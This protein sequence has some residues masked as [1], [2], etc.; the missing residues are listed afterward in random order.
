MSKVMSARRRTLLMFFLFVMFGALAVGYLLTFHLDTVRRIVQQQMLD[1]FGQNLQVGDIQVAFFPSPT[2]TLT[3]LQILESEQGEP[4]FHAARIQMD[5]SF[6]S[7]L[8]DEFVPKGLLIEEPKVY[9]R[10]NEEGQWNVETILQNQ[11]AGSTSVGAFLT[12]YSLTIENGFVQVVDAFNNTP[13]ETIELNRVALDISNLSARKPMDVLFS[14]NLNDDDMSQ[15]S[16]QGTISHV[17]DFF[18]TSQGTKEPSGPNVDVRTQIELNQSALMSFARIFH[19]QDLV[20]PHIGRMKVQS[21]IQYGP[22]LQGY[23]LV[24]SDVIVISDAIDL[25]GQASISGLLAANPPT[26]SATWSSAPIRMKKIIEMLP[27]YII[28]DTVR[29]AIVDQSLDGTI[30]VVSATVSSSSRDDMGVGVSGEFKLSGGSFDLGKKWGVAEHVQGTVFVQPDRVQFQDIQGIYDSIPVSS[31]TANIEFRDT[32]PWLSTELQGTVPSK[33]LLEIVRTVFGW[34]DPDHAMAGF[35]GKSG[36][37]KIKIRFAG[38]LDEPEHIALKHARYDPKQVTLRVPGIEGPLTN[39][40]GTVTFSQHHVSFEPLKGVLG[41]SPIALQGTIKFQDSEVFDTLQF[42]GR[43]FDKDLAIQVGEYSTAIQTIM[44]GVADVVATISGPIDT[45]RIQIRWNLE[46]LDINLGDVLHKEKNVPGTLNLD[47]KFEEGQRLHIHRMTLS[48]PSLSLS[49]HGLFDGNM[50]APFTA[51]ITASPFDLSSL[52]PGLTVFNDE[53]QKGTIEFSLNVD[54]KGND[55]RQWN[56]NGWFALT[57]GALSVEG[58]NSPLSEVVLR[59]KFDRHVA[60]VK[61][62]QFYMQDSQARLA[63]SIHNWETTPKVKFE[64]L[65]PQ[66]DIDLL[67]PK[68]DRSPVREA[69]ESIAATQTVEGKFEFRRAWYKDMK[70]Q[71]LQ[72]RLQIKN[73]IIGVDQIKGTIGSGKIQGRL[74]IHLPV[75]QPAT[76]KTWINM[77][78]VPFQPLETTFLSAENLSEHLVTG[79]LSVQGMVQGHGNDERGIFPTLNGELKILVKDG[80]IRRGTVIPKMLALMN[81]PALLQGKIDLQKEGYPFDTQSGTL[82]IKNGIM[83]S[84]DIIMDGPIL[85]LTGAGTYDFVEDQLDLALVAS[86]LGSYFKLLRKI[87]LF[88]LLLEGDQE[89]IDMAV[90]NV[91]GPINDPVVK[92]LPLESLKTGLTGFAKLAFNV[93]KNTIT[94][95]KTI[96]FPKNSQDSP[97]TLDDQS[98]D[99]QEF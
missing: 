9:L 93:L 24:L 14:A 25:Q 37:G 34:T 26:I 20:P 43:I 42:T 8:Q 84:E 18:T 77:K 82:T 33:K 80:Q 64:L 11:S 98:D 53:L 41:S 39:V 27:A 29:N 23:E 67:I 75:K 3:D 44:S 47:L 89:S 81:L 91:K 12:D 22:G 79:T 40:S 45:P 76:V 73:G 7:V 58:L 59:V 92:S 88:R 96:L 90:F 65:A 52:P 66:F 31:G 63:G 51:S 35:V 32:G 87:P 5:L 28:P 36:S 4:V 62:L 54:G 50:K 68:G 55:W 69:L 60:E 6:L 61:R 16:F 71:D 78:D 74:L 10:R 57:K 2:L 1:A 48:L 56:K 49:G 94:L 95:P 21:Q 83:S 85:R 46:E 70:F 30:E 99:D 97:S 86:P 38:P 72:G 13:P 19:I 17:Y 15:L